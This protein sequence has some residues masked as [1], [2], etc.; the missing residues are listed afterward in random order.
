MWSSARKQVL[1]CEC[2]V[3]N[4]T[5]ESRREAHFPSPAVA[6]FSRC[7]W[8]IRRHLGSKAGDDRCQTPPQ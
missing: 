1:A 3:R 8:Y 7:L 2:S 5:Y 6:T 4:L